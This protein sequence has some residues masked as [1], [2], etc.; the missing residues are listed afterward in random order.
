MPS[1]FTETLPNAGGFLISEAPGMLSRE[2]VTIRQGSAV[3]EPGTV[4]GKCTDN[5]WDV[6]D[7]A[8]TDGNAAV[9]GILYDRVDPTGGAVKG[10]VVDRLA[11]VRAA[12]LTWPTGISS[13]NIDAGIAELLAL[14]IKLRHQAAAVAISTQ[15][16]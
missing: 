2:N 3:L 4:M 12:D 13:A 10:V 8:S 14:H 9:A 15:S 7:E 5:T 16:T 1:N 11:E 6:L